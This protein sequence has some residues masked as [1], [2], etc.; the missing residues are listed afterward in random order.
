MQKA[1][2]HTESVGLTGCSGISLQ[3]ICPLWT[4]LSRNDQDSAEKSKPLNLADLS[5]IKPEY[6][7]NMVVNHWKQSS[8]C[9][10]NYELLTMSPK[11]I[12]LLDQD[13]SEAKFQ[14]KVEP[15]DVMLSDAMATSAAALSSHMG[16]YD[17][18]LEGLSRLHS[19]LGLEMGATMIT[20]VK[21]LRKECVLVKVCIFLLTPVPKTITIAIAITTATATTTITT[22][23]IIKIF[24][25][26]NLIV[27]TTIINIIL[28][29]SSPYISSFFRVRVSSSSFFSLLVFLVILISLY[30]PSSSIIFSVGDRSIAF[31]RF[32]SVFF[33]QQIAIY[34][35]HI[36]RGL[37]LIAVQTLYY[38]HDLS[39]VTDFDTAVQ[40]ALI[41]FFIIHLV[42]AFIALIDTGREVPTWWEKIAR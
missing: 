23:T 21:S 4:C 35:V 25:F 15:K 27:I 1:F 14:G 3:H 2:Y 17:R 22:T 42:L 40:A 7:S 32:I 10:E 18:S 29:C 33:S 34:L 39:G 24:I 13:P 8:E 16:K 9:D 5:D 26:I 38:F 36:L 31:T 30:S 37:P 41:S 28:F 20:D 19:I 12:E 6:L 11:G